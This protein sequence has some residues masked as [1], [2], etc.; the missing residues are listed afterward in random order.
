MSYNSMFSAKVREQTAKSCYLREDV[1]EL[2]KHLCIPT[3]IS[4]RIL[5]PDSAEQL[6]KDGVARLVGLGRTLRVDPEWVVKAKVRKRNVNTCLNCNWCLKRVVLDQGFN[7]RRWSKL[8]QEKTEL[9]IRLLSRNYKGLFVAASAK[10]LD[11]IQ[12]A[13]LN[14]LPERRNIKTAISPTF[15]ILKSQEKKNGFDRKLMEFFEEATKILDRHGFTEAEFQ[16][17]IRPAKKPYDQEVH[18]QIRNGH[19]GLIFIPREMNEP[20]R[21]KIAFRE[22][23]KIIVYI[24]SNAR[25]SDVLVPVDMSINTLLTLM[26]LKQAFMGR[27]GLNLHFVHVRS[28]PERTIEQRWLKIKQIVHLDAHIPLRMIATKGDI[29]EDLLEFIQGRRF[30]TIIMGRRGVSRIKRWLLGSV[31]A[32]LLRHVTD[33]TLFLID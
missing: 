2:T 9:E 33:E 4:G 15:L 3:V 7:C 16:K 25:C 30:D 28:D 27:A 10:D 14:I 22:K 31:S 5:S 8:I 29:A 32:K 1:A 18:L 21:S 19:H 20:W 26:F 13:L 6:I 24:G 23:G 17:I 11:S 12:A